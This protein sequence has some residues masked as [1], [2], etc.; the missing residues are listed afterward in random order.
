[1]V[2]IVPDDK[3]QI[4]KGTTCRNGIRLALT[5]SLVTLLKGNISV[6]SVLE[7]CTTFM[8]ELPMLDE[9]AEEEKET[10][11][12]SQS[13]PV[14][15]KYVHTLQ[16]PSCNDGSPLILIVDDEKEIRDLIRDTLRE[17]YTNVVEAANG[18]EA[19]ELMKTKR[20]NLIICDIMMPEMDGLEFASELKNNIFTNHL[21]IIFLSAKSSIEDQILAAQSGSDIYITKPFHPKHILTAVE[22]ILIKHKLIQ[23]YYNSSANAYELLENGNLIHK[24]DKEFM[25]KLILFI[26]T[27][28][29]DENLSPD[30]VSE[31]LGISKMTLYRKIKDLQNQTP[32]E[33]IKIIKMNKA[34]HLL[35]TTKY[36]IQ[37]IMFKCGFNNKSYFYREF[38]K[39][40]SLTSKE[41]REQHSLNDEKII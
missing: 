16:R 32:S 30:T 19:L 39:L 40:Y 28:M 24:E 37:E 29:E 12:N 23:E 3:F 17:K 36:T 1:M 15:D 8:I 7:Q 22:T 5:K 9:V 10:I 4:E 11:A 31:N 35:I 21:P 26:E 2:D 27:N 33:F 38:L 13:Q 20:P 18:L 6:K 14:F 41:Y 25:L 34:T